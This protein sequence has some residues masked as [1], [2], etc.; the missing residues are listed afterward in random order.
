M[1][2]LALDALSL[3]TKVGAG[4]LIAAEDGL[5]DWSDEG[6]EDDLSTAE[7]GKCHPE[8][9]DELEDVIECCKLMSALYKISVLGLDIRNQ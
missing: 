2:L 5:H 3:R 6:P 4:G 1:Y 7:L 8:D 9:K